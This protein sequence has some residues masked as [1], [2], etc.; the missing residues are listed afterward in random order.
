MI[1]LRSFFTVYIFFCHLSLIAQKPS[2]EFE[3]FKEPYRGKEFQYTETVE[4]AQTPSAFPEALYQLSRFLSHIPWKFIFITILILVF[5]SILYRLYINR[6]FYFHREKG[7]KDLVN[8]DQI[9]ENLTVTDFDRLVDSTE[10]S[11]NYALSIRYLFY[12]NLKG[13]AAKE[14][15]HYQ[16]KKTNRQFL[17]E[18]KD[19][20]LAKA[21]E[22][23]MHAYNRIWFGQNPL[24]SEQYETEKAY[25]LA[26]NKSLK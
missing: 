6:S 25:F 20:S 4:T 7:N 15:I 11:L 3:T 1:A 22:R 12:Q 10:Q 21:Y 24:S 18:I 5:G 16:P 26:F 2:Q 13:L 14:Y 9:E 8:G 19:P 23:N 17:Y